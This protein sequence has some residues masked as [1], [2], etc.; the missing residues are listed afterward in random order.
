MLVSCVGN[1]CLAAMNLNLWGQRLRRGQANTHSHGT[2]DPG[3]VGCSLL[4]RLPPLRRPPCVTPH[5]TD[6]TVTCNVHR[7]TGYSHAFK[8]LLTL[9]LLLKI[10]LHPG[11]AKSSN[12][13]P[14]TSPQEMRAALSRG[15]SRGR[16]LSPADSSH[17][18]RT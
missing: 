2:Q 5:T 10:P 15:P 11:L 8:P 1:E 6:H 13:Q 17:P 4:P 16:E 3:H 18:L 14:F 12:S 7:N 9:F